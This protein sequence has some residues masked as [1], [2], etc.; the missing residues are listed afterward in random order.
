MTNAMSNTFENEWLNLVFRNAD[1]PLI[2][3]ATG[4][5]GSSTAGDLFLAYHTA[6]PGEAGTQTTS[7]C[8]Y[9]GYSRTAISRAG[10]F[11]VTANS[12]SPTADV[13]MAGPKTGGAD[14]TITHFSYGTASAGA[15]K[16][17]Y[18]GPVTP[19]IPV[20]DGVIPRFKSTS[21]GTVD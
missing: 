18:R 9:T 12:V 6:D 19:N 13:D 2:G 11:T 21:A 14:Q 20:T 4:L 15:G 3:D 8:S 16:I 7:E 5:R 1:L 10:G 17:L